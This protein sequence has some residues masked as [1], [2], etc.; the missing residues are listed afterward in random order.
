MRHKRSKFA[1]VRR[2]LKTC[3]YH[4]VGDIRMGGSTIQ[5]ETDDPQ[6]AFDLAKSL[7]DNYHNSWVVVDSAQVTQEEIDAWKK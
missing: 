1:V 5:T 7:S 2:C 3:F 4:N 6:Y